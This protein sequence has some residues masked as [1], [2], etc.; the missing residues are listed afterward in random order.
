M[1]TN[2]E[3]KYDGNKN[4]PLQIVLFSAELFAIFNHDFFFHPSHLHPLSLVLVPAALAP[5]VLIPAA[6]TSRILIPATPVSSV[7]ILTVLTS[8]QSY[9]C[10]FRFSRSR[11]RRSR[12]SR[13]SHFQRLSM[14]VSINLRFLAPFIFTVQTNGNI[15][16][17]ETPSLRLS[18]E[19]SDLARQS[20][21]R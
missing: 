15:Q 16:L 3:H 12:S 13:L 17:N 9:Y 5:L 21:E 11:S 8:P 19:K 20:C 10:S 18:T 4:L 1:V 6:L 14:S 2:R 7:L